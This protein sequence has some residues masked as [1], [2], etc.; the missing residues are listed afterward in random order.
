MS[1]L[2]IIKSRYPNAETFK[3]GDTA[4]LSKRLLDLV[5]AG[6]KTAT[7]GAVSFFGNEGEPMPVVGRRDVALHWDGSPAVVIETTE[8]EIKKFSDVTEDFALSEGENETRAGWARDHQIFF[9]RNGGFNPEMKLVCERF[10]VI[11]V[12]KSF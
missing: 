1:E 5:I 12:I 8:V 9:E 6:K 3:F 4:E 10:K 7:C 11:E 2:E